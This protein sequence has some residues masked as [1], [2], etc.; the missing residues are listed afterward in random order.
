MAQK[1]AVRWSRF[2]LQIVEAVGIVV[3]KS[4]GSVGDRSWLRLQRRRVTARQVLFEKDDSHDVNEV[5]T[6]S[7]H[8][9]HRCGDAPV[10]LCRRR[11][12]SPQPFASDNLRVHGEEQRHDDDGASNRSDGAEY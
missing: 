8:T 9:Q 4:L 2:F 6:A 7:E 3:Q 5:D 10:C 1:S 11:V 12:E